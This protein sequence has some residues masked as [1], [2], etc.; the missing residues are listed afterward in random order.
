MRLLV[1]ILGGLV[2]V[3]LPCS[4]AN[5]GERT[6]N[7][8]AE[9]QDP[10]FGL[11]Y[12]RTTVHY[13]LMPESLRHICP[14]L[15]KG[16]YWIFAHASRKPIDYYLVMGV[17]P[18]QNGDSLGAA[19]WVR[20]S[21]CDSEDSTWMLSGFVPAEGYASQIDTTE[22]PGLKAPQVCDRG[23]LGQCHYVLR[24]QEE[25]AILRELMRD[26][27]SRGIQAWGKERNSA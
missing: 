1:L 19:L 7:T 14:N 2:V 11:S 10:M 15:E 26:G 8:R 12:N 5:S 6:K 24:S 27:I 21:K 9:L 13:E 18:A 20:G 16:T 22:L 4:E 25:E 23:A 17:V 3:H